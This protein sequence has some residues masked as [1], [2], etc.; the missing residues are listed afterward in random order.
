M[1]RRASLLAPSPFARA[2]QADCVARTSMSTRLDPGLRC[3]ATRRIVH[4]RGILDRS[5][6]GTVLSYRDNIGRRL[7]TVE[8]DS[9]EKLI[10]FPHEIEPIAIGSDSGIPA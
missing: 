10:L 9:G 8:F 4:P 1:P 5:S 2:W 7:V 6:E 3:R